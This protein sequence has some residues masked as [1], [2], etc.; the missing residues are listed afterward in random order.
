MKRPDKLTIA[1][2]AIDELAPLVKAAGQH[3]PAEPDGP[4]RWELEWR[5]L[6]VLLSGR[7]LVR[8]DDS[9]LTSIIDIWQGSGPKVLSVN[10]QPSRPWVPPEVATFRSG[11]W[12][13]ELEQLS[14]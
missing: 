9:S 14:P 10:W 11:A 4:S 1:R 8:P 6:Q 3:H 5:G 7:A 2:R 12:V 13:D